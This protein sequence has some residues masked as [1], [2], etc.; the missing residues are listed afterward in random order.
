[1]EH[2]PEILELGKLKHGVVSLSKP[3]AV[4]SP[5]AKKGIKETGWGDNSLG[6][7]FAAQA[8]GP[9][10]GSSAPVKSWVCGS[11]VLGVR[12]QID[13]QG[14]PANWS[15][16][17][18]MKDSTLKNKVETDL[19]LDGPLAFLLIHTGVYTHQHTT[20]T[21]TLQNQTITEINTYSSLISLSIN[22]LNSTIKST[23]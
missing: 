8:W 9:E 10:F 3:R 7:S 18:S 13:H 1:M 14:S 11:P 4:C 22:G 5:Y 19:G 17:G 20:S 15:A 16:T 21:Q 12:R 6:K 2:T 23:G